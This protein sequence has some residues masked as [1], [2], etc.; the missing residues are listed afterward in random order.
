MRSAVIGLRLCGIAEEPFWPR[1]NGSSTSRTSVRAR[2]RISVAKR[3]SDDA[4]SA[5]A[6]SS[7]AW[8][9]RCEDL[10]RGRR[11]LEPEPLA[12]D[13][14]DLRVDRRVGADRA[15]ELADAQPVER[16]RA[17]ARGRGRARTPSR[18]ASGRTWS[19]RR[20]RRGC[21]PMQSVSRCSSARASDGARARASSPSRSSAPASWTAARAPCR[22]RRRRSARS[23]SSGPPRRAA[24]RRRRR[25]RRRRG[26]SRARSRRPRSGVGTTRAAR[27]AAASSGGIDADR[28]PAVE[29]RELDLEPAPEL[30]LVRPDRGH[31]RAGVAGDHLRHSREGCGVH[32]RKRLGLDG[33]GGAVP[34][35]T[36]LGSGA[37]PV[38]AID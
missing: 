21:G 19:A 30:G 12:G 8:R 17:G 36:L 7:S 32:P 29:R 37:L 18:R 25:R 20:G 13:P 24:R 14:L 11:G 26:S 23:G 2:C 15:R 1:P 31:G 6:E 35:S 9:S 10:R 34:E 16:P 27:I 28:G 3:S 33:C 4:T 5:S 38:Q 22:A